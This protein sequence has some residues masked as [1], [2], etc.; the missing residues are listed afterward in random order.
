MGSS[1][2]LIHLLLLSKKN[3]WVEYFEEIHQEALHMSSYF[4]IL[5]DEIYTVKPTPVYLIAK[6]SHRAPFQI[7]RKFFP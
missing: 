1:Q 7:Y 4:K 5:D 2:V 6:L 3:R